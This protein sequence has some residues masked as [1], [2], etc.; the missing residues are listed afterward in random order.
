MVKKKNQINKLKKSNLFW[1]S[2]KKNTGKYVSVF[3]DNRLRICGANIKTYLLEKSRLV[4]QTLNE[5]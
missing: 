1:K 2:K 5:R 4:F 3:F